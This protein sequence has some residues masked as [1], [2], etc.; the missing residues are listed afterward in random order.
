MFIRVILFA[1]QHSML[2][3]IILADLNRAT[4]MRWRMPFTISN[5]CGFSSDALNLFFQYRVL[6]DDSLQDVLRL[7]VQHEL[8][9]PPFEHRWCKRN[10]DDS[11]ELMPSVF[12][13]ICMK[14]SPALDILLLSPTIRSRLHEILPEIC[15]YVSQMDVVRKLFQFK[16]AL[17][18]C[19]PLCLTTAIE[20]NNVEI[21]RELLLHAPDAW[22]L[23]AFTV[24]LHQQ[25]PDF[26]RLLRTEQVVRQPAEDDWTLVVGGAPP[27]RVDSVPWLSFES[28]FFLN[29]SFLPSKN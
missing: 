15:G 5:P 24:A 6:T 17:E 8:I 29:Q 11:I 20:F 28:I 10:Y 12:T 19:W 9:D 25:N 13:E 21:V 18:R 22:F 4:A 23:D 3:C 16:V 1:M 2:L 14:N 27:T 26:L 7:L